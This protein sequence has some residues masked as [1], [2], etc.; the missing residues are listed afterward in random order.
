MEA[1]KGIWNN[2]EIHTGRNIE[3]FLA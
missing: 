2:D 1:V 3:P